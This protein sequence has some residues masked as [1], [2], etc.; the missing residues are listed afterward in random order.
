M[1]VRSGGVLPGRTR[2]ALR[3]GRPLHLAKS[4]V[5]KHSL[6]RVCQFHSGPVGAG[7]VVA[8]GYLAPYHVRGGD[9]ARVVEVLAQSEPAP[10]RAASPLSTT[11]PT[12]IRT[13]S[14]LCRHRSRA[15]LAKPSV[16]CVRPGHAWVHFSC[17]RI[18]LPVAVAKAQ[19]CLL[20]R[21][22]AST[23]RSLLGLFPE[24][25]RLLAAVRHDGR[26]R[27]HHYPPGWRAEPRPARPSAIVD[28]ASRD[29]PH[30]H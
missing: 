9:V 26:R 17:T 27:L 2:L 13:I 15:H 8:T 22:D 24:V 29:D 4:V 7:E 11:A 28:G 3:A 10:G 12:S 25:L 16:S 23:Y 1:P 14:P 20:P 18:C 30:W 19:S 6:A 21:H 5:P